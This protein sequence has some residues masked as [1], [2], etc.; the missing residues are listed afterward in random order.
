MSLSRCFEQFPGLFSLIY[1]LLE[2]KLQRGSSLCELEIS[3]LEPKRFA[4]SV[5]KNFLGAFMSFKTDSL[6]F[7]KVKDLYSNP[8]KSP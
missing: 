6:N 4:V 7:I 1:S 2:Y 5:K 8:R 3:Q